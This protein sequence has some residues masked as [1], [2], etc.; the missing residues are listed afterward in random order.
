MLI[1][2][3]SSNNFK[4]FFWIWFLLVFGFGFF[5]RVWKYI[6]CSKFEK[7]CIIFFFF[8]KKYYKWFDGFNIFLIPK[9]VHIHKNADM[10]RPF[11]WTEQNW[12][13][14]MTLSYKSTQLI[15]LM[16]TIKWEMKMKYSS[17]WIIAHEVD[18]YSVNHS[19]MNKKFINL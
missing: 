2:Y 18:T 6:E 16:L 10:M 9:N 8:K 13:W 1:V 5:G 17:V 3:G 7:E 14:T 12:N 4:F 19:Y 15:Q 11:A